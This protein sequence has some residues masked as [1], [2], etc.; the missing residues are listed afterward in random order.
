MDVPVALRKALEE[1][2]KTA[3]SSSEARNFAKAILPLL[4]AAVTELTSGTT[5]KRAARGTG[6]IEYVV[7]MTEQGE[8]LTERR[9]S[10]RSKPFRCP[11]LVYDALIKAIG[12]GQRPM[13]MDDIMTAVE[14]KLGDRPADFQLRV[15]LRLWMHTEP[16]LVI[17]SRA[18]YRVTGSSFISAASSLWTR[19]SSTT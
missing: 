7:Q 5:V 3:A 17:R 19:L 13:S 18:R 15:P 10:G 12:E 6:K 1:V 16:P 8:T 9:L 14:A 2:A 4:E 11:K